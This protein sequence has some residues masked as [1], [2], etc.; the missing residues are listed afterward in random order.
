M[1][2]KISKKLIRKAFIITITII[3]FLTLLL[4]VLNNKESQTLKMG[5]VELNVKDLDSMVY[6]YKDLVGLEEVSRKDR[7]VDLG[8][9]EA[10]LIR[11]VQNND[12][13]Q[14]LIVENGLY[15]TAIVYPTQKRL[16]EAI[17][18]VFEQQPQLYQGSA[19]H[20]ATEA[21]YFSD[22]EVN[23]VE[24]YF[25]KPRSEWQYNSKGKPLMGSTY[26]DESE[27]I[28]RY[29]RSEDN[30]FNIIMGHIHLKVGTIPEAKKFY[31]DILLF[32]VI[33]ITNETLFVSKDNYHHHIGMNTWHTS[34][35]KPREENTYGLRSFSIK[36][37]DSNIFNLIKENLEKENIEFVYNSDINRLEV[38]DPWNNKLVLELL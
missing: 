16:A 7:I 13:E 35:A 19:D 11:L 1:E 28:D 29:L 24:L 33:S 4:M 23:G 37:L 6:F 21:F 14:P 15:H 31:S 26:I 30:N 10:V 8:D 18:R 9:G 3:I 2:I 22:P 34:G 12:L 27:Y 5:A 25:D 32:D 17:F 20:I 36:Y 38:K